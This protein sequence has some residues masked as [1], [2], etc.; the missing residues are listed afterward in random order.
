VFA[1]VI[2]RWLG[3]ADAK[4]VLGFTSKDGIHPVA[5]LR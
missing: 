1:S 2:D 4:D 5:F 3:R